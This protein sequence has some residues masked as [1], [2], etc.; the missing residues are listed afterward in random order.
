MKTIFLDRDGVINVDTGYVRSWDKFYFLPGVIEA[1]QILTE[2]KF[3]I[4]IVTNQS[5]I[6]RG[7][8]SE[9]DYLRL[10]RK[11]TEFFKTMDIFIAATYY[12]PHLIHGLVKTYSIDCDCRKPSP[13]MLIRAAKEHN[14]DFSQAIMIGD[15]ASDMEAAHSVDIPDRY[16]IDLSMSAPEK[17]Y[18]LSTKRFKSLLDSVKFLTRRS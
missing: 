17:S 6:A 4:I 18:E 7:Y 11:I 3:H 14:L 9:N 15:K 10:E 13:G 12:C 5:G 8:F 1:L 16:F 2:K